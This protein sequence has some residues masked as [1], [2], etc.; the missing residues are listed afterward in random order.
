M[1]KSSSFNMYHLQKI[2][3]SVNFCKRYIS[4]ENEG[5]MVSRAE[6]EENH[7]DILDDSRFIEDIGPLLI[8]GSEWDL[9]KA[10]EF[11][12]QELVVLIPGDP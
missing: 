6:F 2:T 8:V 7:Y 5:H 10:A 12:M 3:K 4:L 1:E 9:A 11:M